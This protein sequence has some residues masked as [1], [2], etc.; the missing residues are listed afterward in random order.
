M[1][2]FNQRFLVNDD[3]REKYREFLNIDA[4]ELFK[5]MKFKP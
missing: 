3:Y 5:K 2:F 1:Y 4:D